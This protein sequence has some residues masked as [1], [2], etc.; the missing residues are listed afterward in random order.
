[1]STKRHKKCGSSE[2]W[3]LVGKKTVF[4]FW[5]FR[6]K[7][8]RKKEMDAVLASANDGNHAFQRFQSW[9]HYPVGYEVFGMEVKSIN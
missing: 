5:G 7:E 8:R 1:M 6:R 3:G 9:R 2:V 4:F